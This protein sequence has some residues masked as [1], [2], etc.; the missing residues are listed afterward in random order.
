MDSNFVRAIVGDGLLTELIISTA[1]KQANVDPSIFHVFSEDSTRLEELRKQYGVRTFENLGE[2]SNAQAV[3][4]ALLPD[5]ADHMIGLIKN[6]IPSDAMIM[7]A[8]FDWRISKLEEHFPTQTIIRATFTPL[9][10][11]GYGIYAYVVGKKQSADAESFAQFVL[12]NLGTV[13][14]VKSE[15]ELE[16]VRDVLLAE[17]TA[18]YIIINSMIEGAMKAGLSL[19]TARKITSQ[20]VQGAARTFIEPD[21][22]IEHLQASL[23]G[24]KFEEDIHREGVALIKKFDM[25]SFADVNGEAKSSQNRGLLKFHYR[26]NSH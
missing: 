13:L 6:I 25:W 8:L 14:K 11:S 26:P 21:A 24:T 15:E 23:K 5:E 2:L 3:I 20:V 16:I 10:V 17:T 12:S 1:F 4:L 7:S 19:A 9:V 18:S 22:V